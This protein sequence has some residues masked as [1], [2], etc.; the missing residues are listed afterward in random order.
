MTTSFDLHDTISVIVPG[1]CVLALL[2]YFSCEDWSG[3]F[4]VLKELSSGVSFVLL[5]PCY[6][7][8][9]LLQ[10]FG[11]IMVKKLMYARPCK[12]PYFWVFNT[13][14]PSDF[15]TINDREKIL[16]SLKVRFPW[17]KTEKIKWN[18]TLL[19]S[20]FYYI[21]LKV[22]EHD[23]YRT[24]CIK[25]LTKMHLF[26]SMTA[27]CVLTPM[28]YMVMS[29][30]SAFR[31]CEIHCLSRAVYIP[32]SCRHYSLGEFFVVCF[33]CGCVGAAWWRLTRDFNR[34]Y[35]RCLYSSYLAMLAKEEKKNETL[36]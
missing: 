24:E 8:G 5:I 33:L 19:N 25:M 30:Y 22:Y 36:D 6:L 11:K 23:A 20:C 29:L 16:N 35:N 13:K 21:K 3:F 15:L 28:I 17:W 10:S 26:A 14:N 2:G 9:E 4:S 32:S 7:A 12:D 1:A 31:C 27:L 34:I 18:E